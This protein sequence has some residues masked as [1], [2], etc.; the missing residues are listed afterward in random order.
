LGFGCVIDAMEQVLAGLFLLVI[1]GFYAWFYTTQKPQPF[2]QTPDV[3]EEERVVAW[4]AGVRAG[5]TGNLLFYMQAAR[6]AVKR[7]QRLHGRRATMNDLEAVSG[8]FSLTDR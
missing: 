7:F 4:I 5:T 6:I 2:Y 1:V 3:A 8:L